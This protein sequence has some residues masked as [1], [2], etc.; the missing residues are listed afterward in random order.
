M[1]QK[2]KEITKKI[3]RKLGGKGIS[4][5]Q[6]EANNSYIEKL[7]NI[8]RVFTD[9]ERQNTENEIKQ[10]TQEERQNTENEIKQSTQEEQQVVQSAMEQEETEINENSTNDYIQKLNQIIDPIFKDD[11]DHQM[12]DDFRKKLR[13]GVRN[14]V[15]I[16]KA[17]AEET[18]EKLK[19][20]RERITQREEEK[21]MDDAQTR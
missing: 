21:N 18:K 4:Q 15:E 16:Y 19:E 10:S 14:I 6:I 20:F 1:I 3:T 8:K 9:E 11:M 17:T 12:P 13:E 2:A 7:S 5:E